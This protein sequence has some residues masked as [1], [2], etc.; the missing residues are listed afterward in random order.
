ML[1]YYFYVAD[2][3]R[4][5][6]FFLLQMM[7]IV[8]FLIPLLGLFAILGLF[9]LFVSK[10][11][12]HTNYIDSFPKDAYILLNTDFSE[13]ILVEKLFL[14]IVIG[15]PITLKYLITNLKYLI[16]NLK[17]LITKPVPL[18]D[19]GFVLPAAAVSLLILGISVYIYRSYR[20]KPE[21]KIK[22]MLIPVIWDGFKRYA[23]VDLN[24]PSGTHLKDLY[25]G[26]L[27]TLYPEN[28]RDNIP[29][30]LAWRLISICTIFDRNSNN[31]F[32]GM[33]PYNQYTTDWY[34]DK[35][36][37]KLTNP[38]K[39]DP[40][41]IESSLAHPYDLAFMNSKYKVTVYTGDREMEEIDPTVKPVMIKCELQWVREIGEVL[42]IHHRYD[43]QKMGHSVP[44]P[45]RG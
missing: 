14:N 1:Y 31:Y 13:S 19:D 28:L 42:E 11:T 29:G 39:N 9:F 18:V 30:Y 24:D 10:D 4:S 12:T 3:R 36:I 20:N 41:Y 40:Y 43:L 2:L 27:Y 16:T 22:L 45:T 7:L 38:N 32:T 25:A 44:R 37:N 21:I 26:R 8:F 23:L 35:L 5:S 34:Y 33:L 6:F 17:D 15:S